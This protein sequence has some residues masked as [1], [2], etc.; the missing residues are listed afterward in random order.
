M[1]NGRLAIGV[2]FLLNGIGWA[3]WAS[4]L[5]AIR[6]NLSIG[7]GGL[8]LALLAATA[9]LFVSAAASDRLIHRFGSRRV[10]VGAA[11]VMAATLPAIGWAPGY[12]TFV[13]ALLLF[14]LGNG[15]LDVASNAQAVALQRQGSR[16]ILSG[17]HA[18]FSGGAIVGAGSAA[19][20]AAAG[21]PVGPHLTI[22]GIV[23]GLAALGVG[24]GLIADSERTEP[25]KALALP[26]GPML[27][28][29]A[30]AFCVLL[31]EGAVFDWSAVYLSTVADAAPALAAVG[32]GI[33]Q[34]AMLVGRLV[35]DRLADRLRPY[36]LVRWGT[37][38][39][40]SGMVLATV[41]PGPPPRC[42]GTSSSGSA[43][44][45]ASRLRSVP[46]PGCP[47]WRRRPPSPRR[48]HRGTSG[49]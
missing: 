41:V 44:R 29:A 6:E 13:V 43:S 48:P 11:V 22:V 9:G 12:P 18:A 36:R 16:S 34:A 17:V 37:L 23:I 46:R 45:L 24:G 32:L 7:E 39:G 8:G 31:A 40:A 19:L 42:Q 4:R 26:R 2:V 1:R 27:G 10:T 33:F 5:P 28:F 15:A 25:P 30:L 38:L 47:A 21:V 35:G 20:L 49:S 3:S 14:G